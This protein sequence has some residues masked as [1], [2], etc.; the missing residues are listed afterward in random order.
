M[1][2]RNSQRFIR[3]IIGCKNKH[4][5]FITKKPWNVAAHSWFVKIL[6]FVID[7]KT[8]DVVL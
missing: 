4:L 5:I 7:Y 2:N 1:Q 3:A 8:H 6:N